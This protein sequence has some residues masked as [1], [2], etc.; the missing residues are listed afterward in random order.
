MSAHSPTATPVF[1]D[2]L[3]RQR[4]G[5]SHLHHEDAGVCLLVDERVIPPELLARQKRAAL[6]PGGAPRP[7]AHHNLPAN[8]EIDILNGKRL[9]LFERE[10]FQT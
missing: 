7:A 2:V 4:I 6:E 5:A 9:K 8:R 3:Q 10:T 1:D